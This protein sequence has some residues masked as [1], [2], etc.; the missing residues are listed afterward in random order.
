VACGEA[1]EVALASGEFV[2]RVAGGEDDPVDVEPFTA[3]QGEPV[4]A[5][6]PDDVLDALL[7]AAQ[8]YAGRQ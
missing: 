3:G 8:P 7:D 1:G 5:G 2:A 6:A 4:A